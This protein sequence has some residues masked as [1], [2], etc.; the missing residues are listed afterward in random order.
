MVNI[1]AAC[2]LGRISI[3]KCDGSFFGFVNCVRGGLTLACCLHTNCALSLRPLW[4]FSL[5][6]KGDNLLFTFCGG[7]KRNYVDFFFSVP[8]PH[9]LHSFCHFVPATI[10]YSTLEI[11]NVQMELDTVL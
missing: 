1:G 3:K 11:S 6:R 7:K 4:F 8:S 5:L 10:F 2:C 9:L